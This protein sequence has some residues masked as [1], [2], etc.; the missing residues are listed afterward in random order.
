MSKNKNIDSLTGIWEIFEE[1]K[2]N[3]MKEKEYII[4]GCDH[5][6]YAIFKEIK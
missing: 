3:K 5:N 4:V 6:G 1:P 2:L